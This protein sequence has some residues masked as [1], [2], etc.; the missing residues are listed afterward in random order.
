LALA[1]QAG[2]DPSLP[3]NF[4][5]GLAEVGA[6]LARLTGKST[7]MGRGAIGLLSRRGTYSIDKA[8]RLLGFGPK[9]DSPKACVAQ[10]RGRGLLTCL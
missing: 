7:E 2:F 5:I 4:A 1:R 8:R 6:K 3:R 9:V 10:R